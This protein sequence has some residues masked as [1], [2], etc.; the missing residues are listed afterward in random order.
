MKLYGSADKA[1]QKKMLFGPSAAF[2][3]SNG[4]LGPGTNYG[5]VLSFKNYP[6]LQLNFE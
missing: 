1:L 4:R 6:P 5:G 3:T 2:G